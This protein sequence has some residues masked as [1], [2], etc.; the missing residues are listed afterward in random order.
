MW[1]NPTSQR[2]RISNNIL[3]YLVFYDRQ[4][5]NLLSGLIVMFCSHLIIHTGNKTDENI[6]QSW[7]QALITCSL[8]CGPVARRWLS[9]LV[10]HPAREKPVT[11][12]EATEKMEGGGGGCREKLTCLVAP[13]VIKTQ[14]WM[15]Q[16]DNKGE[17]N[18]GLL[19]F[20]H[21]SPL[22]SFSLF[23]FHTSLGSPHQPGTDT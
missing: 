6:K 11:L 23:S 7:A 14:G 8:V 17:T 1:Q 12:R 10:K 2:S 18:E 3:R 21:C 20:R 16:S 22:L 4:S 13:D 9:L 15:W 5:F 19:H